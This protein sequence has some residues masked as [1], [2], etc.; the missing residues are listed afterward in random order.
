M[1]NRGDSNVNSLDISLQDRD[2][3]IWLR[4]EKLIQPQHQ[5]KRIP[6]AKCIDQEFKVDDLI[7]LRL[8]W[9]HQ[10]FIAW[11]GNRKL[12]PNF[13][14]L[15]PIQ[16]RIAQEAYKLQLLVGLAIHPLFHVSHLKKKLGR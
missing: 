15:F 4:R 6:N 10:A 12:A 5:M 9:F 8:Q 1:Y 14:R 7:F 16:V 2:K 11:K 3:M 13:Y